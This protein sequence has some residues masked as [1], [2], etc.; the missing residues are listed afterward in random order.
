M[1]KKEGEDIVVFLGEGSRCEGNI[2][3]GGGV[4]IDG[5][6][7]GDITTKGHFIVG[8]KGSVESNK[9]EAKTATLAGKVLAEL[10]APQKVTLKATAHFEGTIKTRSLVIEEGAYF[11]G[12]SHQ[13]RQGEGK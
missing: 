4:R 13:E 10:Y 8:D 12:H 7:K 2:T 3:S 5:E 1:N 11:S 6:F 9:I